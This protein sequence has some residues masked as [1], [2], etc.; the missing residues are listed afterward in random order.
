MAGATAHRFR[1]PLVGLAALALLT[2]FALWLLRTPAPAPEIPDS[3]S[4]ALAPPPSAPHTPTATIAVDYS[5]DGVPIH[6]TGNAKIDAQ[7]ML[8]HPITPSHERIFHENE[9][10]ADLNGAMDVRDA[11]GLRRLLAQYRSEFPEDAHVLQD[12]YELIANCM[13]RPCPETRA[14][15]QRYYDEQLDSGLRRYIRRHCLQ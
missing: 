13:E 15:A 6:P 12:G 1:A 4:E 2:L 5:P 14:V 8:P 11:S 3:R 10:I 7:G 9:L